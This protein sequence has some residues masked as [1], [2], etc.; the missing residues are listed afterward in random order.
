[1]TINDDILELLSRGL[2]ADLNR[3]EMRRLYRL[4][5]EDDDVRAEAGALALMEDDFA[6]FAADLAE[7]EPGSELSHKIRE[8]LAEEQQK[9]PKETKQSGGFLGWLH[10]P[11]GISM[12]PLSFV[13]G[14][15]VAALAWVL[16]TPAAEQMGIAP[17]PEI[18]RFQVS[19]MHFKQAEAEVDW[20][21]QFI[22]MPGGATRVALDQGDD[23]PMHFQFESTEPAPLTV[24]HHSKNRKKPQLHSFTVDGIGVADLKNPLPGDSLVVHNNGQVP[25]VVYAYTNGYGGSWVL[26]ADKNGDG[27]SL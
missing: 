22:V 8:A 6:A 27:T 17:K 26:P 23:L 19:D 16:I 3:A 12:Q 1:M 25:V 11:H 10:S 15:A 2:D 7:A 4:V 24:A 21:Y 9:Q 5:A 18:A 13:S 20:T 14:L